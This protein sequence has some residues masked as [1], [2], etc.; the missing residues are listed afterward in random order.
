MSITKAERAELFQR[1]NLPKVEENKRDSIHSTASMMQL[2]IT[3]IK[4][5]NPMEENQDPTKMIAQ[6]AQMSQVEHASK[7]NEKLDKVI[8]LLKSSKQFEA[9]SL[10]DKNIIA[11]GD[12]IKL[13]NFHIDRNDDK[14]NLKFDKI[15]GKIELPKIPVGE[16]QK[17][18]RYSEVKL[19]IT[20]LDKKEIATIKLGPQ[21]SGAVVP[22][23]LTKLENINL[24]NLS[25]Q[26]LN[27][28]LSGK[29]KVKAQGISGNHPF[30]AQTHVGTKI[31]SVAIDGQDYV[32][33]GDGSKK[34][35]VT[36][37]N[38]IY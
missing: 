19:K 11:P 20:T 23:E 15:K 16:G 6:L 24:K 13:D 38:E 3:Q 9:A 31:S 37:L 8:E 2:F 27:A 28:I 25:D 29:I 14:V 32:V 18:K 5:Q 36:D 26:Q 4:N 12:N 7:T 17:A 33:S 34:I 35:K 30:E 1:A 21:A 22:F 10:L